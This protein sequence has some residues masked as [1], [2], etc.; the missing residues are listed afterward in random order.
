MNDK[1]ILPTLL[2]MTMLLSSCASG[3]AENETTTDGDA[4]TGT[5]AETTNP[6]YA[7]LPAGDFGGETLKFLGENM[8]T[9]AI[10]ELC[11]DEL[12]GDLIND[13]MYAIDRRVEDKLNIKITAEYRPASG[14]LRDVVNTAMMSGD[15]EY[16]V[17]I[18]LHTSRPG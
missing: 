13:T 16:D 5:E 2:L 9:W 6:L 3:G 7:D 12:D 11:A 1:R 10:I 14:E 4:G 15:D 18:S 17:K 8:T